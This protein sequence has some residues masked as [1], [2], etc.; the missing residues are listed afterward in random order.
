MEALIIIAIV[1]ALAYYAY[2][3]E[4]GPSYGVNVP[5]GLGQIAYTDI[6]NLASSAGFSGQDVQTAVAI[7]LAESSGNVDAYNPERFATGGTPTGMGS[8]GLWQ[9]YLRDHP[10]FSDVNLYDPQANAN[11]AFQIYSASGF[12][13]WSTYN[14]GAYTAYLGS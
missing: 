14:S 3:N 1:F 13:A 9:I 10:E 6:A 12:G 2:S 7:A 8:Y 4:P 5:T 11:A